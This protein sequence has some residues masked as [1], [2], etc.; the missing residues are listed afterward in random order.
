MK[1]R[2]FFS[3]VLHLKVIKHLWVLFFVFREIENVVLATLEPQP[4]SV[5]TTEQQN[6]IKQQRKRIDS[7]FRRQLV[8]PLLNLEDLMDEYEDWLGEEE[9]VS[10]DLEKAHNTAIDA[11]EKIREFENKLEDEVM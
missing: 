3:L 6:A 9:E 10:D 1:A 4:G 5:L 8:V 2:Y 7:I 11:L